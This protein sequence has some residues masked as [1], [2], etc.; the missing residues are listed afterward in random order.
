MEKL[1]LDVKRM[2]DSIPVPEYKLNATVE[3]AIEIGKNQR[4]RSFMNK[5]NALAS[6]AAVFILAIGTLLISSYDRNSLTG[7]SEKIIPYEDSIFYQ[8]S[9]DEGLKRMAMEGRTKDLLL[10]AEDQGIKVFLEK[11]YLD[12]KQLALS[13]RLE[14][15]ENAD[16]KAKTL[17]KTDI[18]TM[19]LVDGL[20]KGPSGYSGMPTKDVI[21]KGW[22]MTFDATKGIPSNP[23]LELR[24][25][26]INGIQGN[27]DF[28]FKLKKEE[29]YIAVSDTPE[30]NDKN[31]NSFS[32][33]H[34]ELT[35]TNLQLRTTTQVK[36][37]KE[38]PKYSFLEFSIVAPGNNGFTHIIKMHGRS[39]NKDNVYSGLLPSDL[40]L[41]EQIDIP[42]ET[43]SYSYKIV[44]YIFTFKGEETA[45][46]SGIMADEY[47]TPFKAGTVLEGKSDIKA[48]AIKT[49]QEKT[50]VTY[51]MALNPV[52]PKFPVIADREKT[53]WL[54]ASSFREKDGYVEVVYPK[55]ENP[56]EVEFVLWDTSYILFP[57]LEIDL[58]LK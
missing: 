55:V 22:V 51:D 1:H 29:E 15:A 24:I 23:E 45:D 3:A 11:G 41:N 49:D 5:Q 46:K 19:L 48:V 35:P 20:S 54:T 47:Y 30:K 33:N 7:Q 42:R 21:E 38:M 43:N 40:T 25:D 57:E 31:G 2:V 27:W 28:K 26:S 56:D 53:Q 13:Y 12:N 4:K 14:F 16:L 58:K 10:V 37:E 39:S 9:L 8:A 6:I 18:S 44:P 32:V 36:L 34:A 50:V 17:E 52:V